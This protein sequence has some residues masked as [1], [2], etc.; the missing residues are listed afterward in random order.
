[1]DKG[2]LLKI[3]FDFPWKV[4]QQNQGPQVII[5]LFLVITKQCINTLFH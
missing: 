1:M 2:I 4:I 5:W 3:P